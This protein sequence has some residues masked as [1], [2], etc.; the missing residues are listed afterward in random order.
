MILRVGGGR[1]LLKAIQQLG[2][3]PWIPQKEPSQHRLKSRGLPIAAGFAWAGSPAGPITPASDL[4][5]LVLTQQRLE[6]PQRTGLGLGLH[7]LHH[8][9]VQMLRSGR[10]VTLPQPLMEFPHRISEPGQ[11]QGT[12]LGIG[13]GRRHARQPASGRGTVALRRPREC[14]R[15]R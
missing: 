10:P 2:K 6:D 9:L 12:E 7:F 14:F 3:P 1:C 11:L 5:P 4:L 15:R 13:V 8:R